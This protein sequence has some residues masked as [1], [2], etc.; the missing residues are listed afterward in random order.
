MSTKKFHVAY[1]T[2]ENYAM[3]TAVSI[4]SLIINKS[5]DVLIMD[6]PDNNL[7]ATAIAELIKKINFYKQNHITIIISH[8]D[9]ILS[10]ADE[11]VKF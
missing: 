3:P 10:I 2:D 8:D 11:V 7:D 9:R 1:I 4:V 5:A 6:E